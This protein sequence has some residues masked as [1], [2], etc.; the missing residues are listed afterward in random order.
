V[1]CI[2]T[3]GF[4]R[5]SWYGL[6]KDLGFSHVGQT[7]DVEEA[8]GAKVG[9]ITKHVHYRKDAGFPGGYGNVGPSKI[10]GG[11]ITSSAA[12]DGIRIQSELLLLSLPAEDLHLVVVDVTRNIVSLLLHLMLV[13]DTFVTTDHHP[14]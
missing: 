2:P 5:Y 3:P 12:K 9:G 7:V 14:K 10:G 13:L 4:E 6:G 1:Y 11:R 8:R